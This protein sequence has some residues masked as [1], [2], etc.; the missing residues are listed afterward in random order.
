MRELVLRWRKRGLIYG[1]SGNLWWAQKWALQPT[2]FLRPDGSIRV[3]VGFR[4]TEGVS[5]IGYVDVSGADPSRV[6]KVTTEP[7][8][9]IGSPG[10]FDENGVVPC[11]VVQRADKIYLYYAGYQLG[12]KVR[13]YV[14]GGLAISTDGGESF[15]RYSRAPIAD[16]TD[17]E[18]LFRVIHTVM[19]EEGK[20][21]A[22]YGA[23]SRFDVV[24]GRQLPV[25]DIRHAY[26]TDGTTLSRD[27]K[28]C[29]E[30]KGNEYRVGRPYV[31]RHAGVYKMLYAAGSLD[32]GYQLAY[33]ESPDGLNWAR[34]DDEV[35][36]EKSLSGWDS[37]MQCYPAVVMNG[38]Y[39]YLFYNGNNYGEDGFGYAVLE[40]W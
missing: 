33:G 29:I 23:G 15:V 24:S 18:L 6:L 32:G 17:D 27:F 13:F 28:L 26:A 8:L 14:F 40:H 19:S 37:Q 12:Q 22:W 30:T 1:P 7:V 35:G 16:R 5:R 25:Y 9:D 2:P 39:T 21:R 36:I 10:M 20:W 31:F 3:F 11:A 34:K 38:Q 4:T